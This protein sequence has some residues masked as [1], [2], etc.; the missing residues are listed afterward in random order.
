MGTMKVLLATVL[1]W[2]RL[3]KS[4]GQGF[5][6]V[7]HVLLSLAATATVSCVA[8]QTGHPL[9]ALCIL[10]SAIGAFVLV[11]LRPHNVFD[12]ELA[13]D[14]SSFLPH[15]ARHF[16]RDLS[17]FI[18]L[19]KTHFSTI[20]CVLRSLAS[21]PTQPCISCEDAARDSVHLYHVILATSHTLRAPPSH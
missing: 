11:I 1:K 14:Y 12:G 15:V 8:A 3:G 18:D 10:A 6:V 17:A 21:V 5:Y 13:G 20:F 16:Y 4:V 7:W 2:I 19:L 9:V